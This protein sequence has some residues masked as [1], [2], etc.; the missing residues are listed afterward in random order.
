[1]LANFKREGKTPSR[2]DILIIVHR[3]STRKGANSV[4]IK[5]GKLLGPDALDKLR[6][7]IIDKISS[8]LQALRKILSLLDCLR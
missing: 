1:M 2:K 3:G 6:S 8:F 7:E 4:R 5:D